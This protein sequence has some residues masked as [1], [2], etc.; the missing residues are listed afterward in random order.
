M[1]NSVATPDRILVAGG[2]GFLGS[3][4]CRRLLDDGHEVICLDNFVTGS[5]RNIEELTDNPRFRLVRHDVVRPVPDDIAPNR[6]YNLACPASPRHYQADP[7]HT[8]RTCV[9]G[10]DNLLDCA[11]RHRASF[12]QAS[13]SEVYGDPQVHPQTEA[14]RGNVNPVGVRSCYDEGKRGAESLCGDYRRRR[15][16]DV[17]IARIF[18]TYGPGMSMDDGRLV[19]N[20]MLQ[21][22]RGEDLTIY[23]EGDQ[24]R[25]LCYVDDMIEG[26]LR[27]MRSSASF[28]GPVNLGNP[29]ERTVLD[30]AR[31]IR[32][33]SASGARYV[34]RPLPAD[35]PARR[36][37]D[38]LLARRHLNWEPSVGLEEGL[39]RTMDYFRC[40]LDAVPMGH[41]VA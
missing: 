6:I 8:F 24:T 19:S 20:L 22:L 15:K 18:N 12:V 9:I 39:R 31:Q 10:T 34:F 13:T 2:A 28:C 30:I 3:H 26:L 40:E 36:C 33:L 17:K 25:S 4:L 32:R 11:V 41:R 38:I 14:Y 37:P 35:D 29:D 5:E 21:A 16:V 1:M 27:L 7:I 23:G